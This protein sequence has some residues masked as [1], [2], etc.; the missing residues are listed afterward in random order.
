MHPYYAERESLIRAQFL[1]SLEWIRGDLEPSLSRHSV[2]GVRGLMLDEFAARLEQLPYV[3]GDGG[4]MTRFFEVAAGF[5]AVGRVLRRLD[6]PM[7]TTTHLMR[8]FFLGTFE[9]MTDEQRESFGRHWLSAQNIAFLREQAAQSQ[10][11]EHAGDFVYRFVEAGTT[12]D[13]E[14]FSFGL[15]YT[16]CGFCKLAKVHHDEDILPVMCGLDEEIYAMRHIK[17]S[18]T[19]TIAG[20]A[21]HCNFRFAPA[22]EPEP[23]PA[24]THPATSATVTIRSIPIH[25]IDKRP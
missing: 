16:Q 8:R 20:G 11:E 10:R 6:V 3:G 9:Q 21:S 25:P 15:D 5:F 13:G 19:Q 22:P 2:D 4:R 14:A 1:N 24:A 12:P 18:R 17:L 7:P 23:E